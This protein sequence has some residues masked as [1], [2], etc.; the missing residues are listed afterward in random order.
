MINIAF[1]SLET[2]IAWICYSAVHIRQKLF[3][4]ILSNYEIRCNFF[5]FLKYFLAQA[6]MIY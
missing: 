2:Y 1:P 6:C 4:N 3:Q 5:W